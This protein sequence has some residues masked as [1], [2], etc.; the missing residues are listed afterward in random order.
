VSF[1][2]I[3]TFG[4]MIGGA[5]ALLVLGLTIAGRSGNH[6]S[7]TVELVSRDETYSL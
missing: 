6:S 5:T 7:R 4:Y 2:I 1:I 3:F